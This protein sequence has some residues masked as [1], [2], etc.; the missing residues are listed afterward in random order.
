MNKKNTIN[1]EVGILILLLSFTFLVSK[2]FQIY[3]LPDKYFYDSNSILFSLISGIVP[4]DKSYG[5]TVLFYTPLYNVFQFQSVEGWSIA[6]AIVFDVFFIF[7]ILK[8]LKFTT[9][10]SKLM[11]MATAFLLNI[12]VFTLSKDLIQFLLYCLV[13]FI[14]FCKIKMGLKLFFL[15]LVFCLEAY[16]FR[17]YYVFY[18]PFLF[19]IYYFTRK[20]DSIFKILLKMIA[21]FFFILTFS[22]IFLKDQ[23]NNLVN[24]RSIVNDYREGSPDAN[25]MIS[26]PI[27]VDNVFLYILAYVMNFLRICLPF[28]LLFK[29]NIIYIAFVF[30][31]IALMYA[32]IKYYKSNNRTQNHDLLWALALT[33][34]MVSATFEP[35]FG[36][37][38]RHEIAFAP[39]LITFVDSVVFQRVM[40][41]KSLKVSI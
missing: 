19:C 15:M 31:Q 1:A 30:Y 37:V 6:F 27:A 35:D 17:S 34:L 26:N 40:N 25:T 8:N 18:I 41:K 38:L 32:L 13:Y 29:G 11:I 10:F 4:S 3:F 12:Y 16:F 23:Y 39:I 21:V 36:S 5:F 9:F 2:I 28:E 24:I 22:S 14:V 20:N 33:Y 7:F